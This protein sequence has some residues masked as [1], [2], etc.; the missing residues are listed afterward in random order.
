MT[1]GMFALLLAGALVVP[2]V[3]PA[4]GR[5]HPARVPHPVGA[6]S[7]LS[8]HRAG[9]GAGSPAVGLSALPARFHP[10]LSHAFA[11]ACMAASRVGSNPC[12]CW[13][14]PSRTEELIIHIQGMPLGVAPTS[15]IR[16]MHLLLQ[17]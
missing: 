9:D 7:A 11:N 4:L 8:G 12:D 14:P 17:Y 15:A 3:T 16:P 5:R 6:W 2:H 13:P 10:S 1:K